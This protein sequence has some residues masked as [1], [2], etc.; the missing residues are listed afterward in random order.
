M[1]E[2]ISSIIACQEKSNAFPM[3]FAATALNG[4]IPMPF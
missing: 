2:D 1:L 4:I 3:P